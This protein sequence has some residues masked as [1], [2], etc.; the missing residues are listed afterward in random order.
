MDLHEGFL[1]PPSLY[2]SAPFWSWN[3]RLTDEELVRQ[4]QAFHEQGIGGFFMHSRVGLLTDYLSD[5]WMERVRTCV[6]EARRLD[7]KAWLYDEDSYPSGYA[8]GFVPKISKDFRAKGLRLAVLES[9][10]DVPEC[11]VAAFRLKRDG[12]KVVDA[13]RVGPEEIGSSDDVAAFHMVYA[14]DSTWHN[15][16]SYIDT[17]NPDAVEEFIRITHEAYKE[18]FG[19]DFGGVIPGIFTDEPQ[20]AANGCP[21]PC[22]PWTDKF[23]EHFQERK[24]YDLTPL[25]PSLFLEVGDHRKAR[26]DF[27]DVHTQLFAEIFCKRLYDWC[28]ENGL[29][30]TGHFWEHTFPGVEHSGSTM[31]HHEYMQMPGIDL[32]FNQYDYLR[33]RGQGMQFGNVMI[34]REVGSVAR[35]MGHQQVL[36]ETYG[37]AGWELSFREQKRIGDW[38]YVLG[39]NFLCQHLSLMSLRGCRKRDFPPSFLPHQPWWPEYRLLGDYFGRL[40]FLLSQG[41]AVAD[42]L[43]LHPYA[44]IWALTGGQSVDPMVG[45]IASAFLDLN[46]LMAEIHRGF[47]LGDET[48]IDRHGR[49]EG[50][51]FVVGRAAYQAVVVPPCLLIRGMT[52][53]LLE[54]FAANGGR[55][56]FVEP[57]PTLVDAEVSSRLDALLGH[58]NSTRV[59]LDADAI[60]EGLSV[61][62]PDV[63]L[64]D[65]AGSGA[66]PVY[67]QH[68]IVDDQHLVFLTNVD[69]ERSFDLVVGLPEAQRVTRW[70]PTDGSAE[71]LSTT[72]DGDFTQVRV[73]LPPCG[74]AVLVTDGDEE[75]Q[76]AAPKLQ[77]RKR[78]PLDAITGRPAGPNTA[79]L[80]RCTYRIGD[81]DWSEPTYIQAAFGAIREHFGLAHDNDNRGVQL[82]LAHRDL[83]PLEGDTRVALRYEL[84]LACDPPQELYFVS[85]IAERLTFEVNGQPVTPS[86]DSLFDP[87]FRKIDIHEQ[88]RKGVNEI[89]VRCDPF[90]ADVEL[91]ASYLAGDFAAAW[92]G[93]RIVLNKPPEAVK[94][95]NW[96]DQGYPFFAGVMCYQARADLGQPAA[97]ER[98]FVC[99]DKW[100]GAVVRV[101]VNGKEVGPIAWPPYERDVTD[102]ATAGQNEIAVEVVTSLRN[103]LGPHHMKEYVPGM[104]APGFFYQEGNWRDDYDLVPQGLMEAPWV[105]VRG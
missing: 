32:L 45:E 35:Q 5:E 26:L 51:S 23:L 85:E 52:L 36:S 68:R 91:E 92:D 41:E 79:I 19:D 7:M 18:R 82:W 56:V 59:E 27:W 43:V 10:D 25:L 24:G 44:S 87:A 78:I 40:S 70:D 3:D 34:V 1:D 65:E 88:V 83:K 62:P 60:R 97:G 29:M 21:G 48:L 53:S 12:E 22:V 63:T 30:L 93:S 98:I 96:L 74:S 55:I 33:P 61:V 104:V 17:R 76:P 31:P 2:R 99:L 94:L 13:V 86:D 8:G 50:T 58:K 20:T 9:G 101:C 90:A 66:E 75:A 42:V 28:E 14:A 100:E 71:E 95:G 15:G 102:A 39:I 72:S 64:A 73:H 37:G 103:L 38:E 69:E 54:R 77:A 47:D 81:A 6:E 11:L 57:V 4:I 89:I 80:D 105:E 67:Y 49:I 84:D 16:Y 46:R